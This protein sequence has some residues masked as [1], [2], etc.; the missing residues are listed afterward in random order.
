MSNFFLNISWVSFMLIESGNHKSS[1]LW[2]RKQQT[3]S[4]QISA[5]AFKVWHSQLRAQCRGPQ[6]TSKCWPRMQIPFVKKKKKTALKL[7]W[8]CSRLFEDERERGVFLGE[9][10]LVKP[11][12]ITPLG[13]WL[14]GERETRWLW[15]SVHIL[16]RRPALCFSRDSYASRTSLVISNKPTV[17]IK[18]HIG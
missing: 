11:P 6:S 8:N 15:L 16:A 3:L 7:V 9:I 18:L 2:K 4:P 14:D 1:A 5:R 13:E 10:V 12:S 17:I